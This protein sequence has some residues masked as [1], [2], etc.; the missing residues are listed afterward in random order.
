MRR[1]LLPLLLLGACLG[2]GREVVEAP[3]VVRATIAPD[4]EVMLAPTRVRIGIADLALGDAQ[5]AVV[6]S[7][8]RRVDADPLEGTDLGTLLAF[9]GEAA[10]ARF[11]LTPD[12]TRAAPS[13]D[14]RGVAVLPDDREVPFAF[15]DDT[16]YVGVV[17]TGLTIPLDAELADAGLL[18]TLDLDRVLADVPWADAPSDTTLTL[19]DEGVAPAIRTGLEDPAAWRIV[20]ADA[21]DDPPLP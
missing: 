15:V 16:T 17:L 10:V 2:P 11:A 13:F 20:R 14:A 12:P 21:E 9:D 19:A 4:A 7:W 5:G 18:W 8:P 3:L 1:V 6:G